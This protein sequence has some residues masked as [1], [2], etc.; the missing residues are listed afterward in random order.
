MRAGKEEVFRRVQEGVG[1]VLAPGMEHL[2]PFIGESGFPVCPQRRV[3]LS[4]VPPCL[5]RLRIILIRE[6]ERLESKPCVVILLELHL[7]KAQV[8]PGVYPLRRGGIGADKL[9]QLLGGEV[10]QAVVVEVYRELEIGVFLGI[11][12]S[13]ESGSGQKRWN[14][15]QME[16]YSAK[17]HGAG[18]NLRHICQ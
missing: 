3:G 5:G 9:P 2:D 6:R 14:D 15:E 1:S 16:E 4:H 17:V 10:V 18:T 8:V 12:G 11:L 7:H 13:R